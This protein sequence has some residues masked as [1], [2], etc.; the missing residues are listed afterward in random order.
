LS[1]LVVIQNSTAEF[2]KSVL[3]LYLNEPTLTHNQ[4]TD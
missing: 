3:L 4:L 1:G 2:D